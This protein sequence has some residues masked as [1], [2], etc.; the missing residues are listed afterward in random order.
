MKITGVAFVL[1]LAAILGGCV[2]T[3][4]EQA[5]TELA[6]ICE[7]R[8]PDMRIDSPK[9]ESRGGMFGNVVVTG[10]CVA[11]ED[12]GYAEA[13]TIEEYRASLGKTPN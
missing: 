4:I 7:A 8:G 9:A 13:M 3:A 10:N 5:G 1:P 6:D 2:S 12:E 11:P